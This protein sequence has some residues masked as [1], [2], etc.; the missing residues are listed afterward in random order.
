MASGLP[1]IVPN[2]SAFPEILAH[3]GGVLMEQENPEI[4]ANKIVSMLND[5]NFI[6]RLGQEGIASVRSNFTWKSVAQRLDSLFE[7]QCKNS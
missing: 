4:Y 6:S 5:S 3:G 7:A 1:V 2:G